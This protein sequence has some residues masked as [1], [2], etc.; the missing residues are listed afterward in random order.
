MTFRL[1]PY[2]IRVRGQIVFPL[3][4]LAFS[5][6]YYVQ[7][8]GLKRE[9]LIFAGPILYLCGA[10]AVYLIL[11]EGLVIT[12]QDARM[13]DTTTNMT[14]VRGH[15]ASQT[16]MIA[17]CVGVVTYVLLLEYVGFILLSLVFLVCAMLQLGT[18]KISVLV[19][20]P[21]ILVGSIYFLFERWLRVPLPKGL[22]ENLL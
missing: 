16:R 14:I 18:R 1:G 5:I 13:A 9:S 4:A 15:L 11:R 3:L 21:L 19:L 8:P 12:R 22:W 10:L 17:L 6:A 20:V 2:E 7:V